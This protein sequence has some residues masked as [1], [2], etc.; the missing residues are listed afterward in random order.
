MKYGINTLIFTGTFTDEDARVFETIAQMGF[1]G[2]EIALEKKGDFDYGSVLKK[3]RNNDLECSSI[4][5]L[6]GPDRDVRGPNKEY[7]KNGIAYIKDCIDAAYELEAGLVIGPLYSSVGR[8]NMESDEAKKEQWATARESL[9]EVCE[10]AEKKGID[11]ALEPL[12]RFETDFINI[13]RDA[14]AMVDEVGSSRLGIHLDAFHMNIE[15]KNSA[16]AV[17]AA[18]KKLFH[19]HASENDRGTP[20]T[21]Q[22]RWDEIAAAFKEIDYNRY[23]VIE[24]FTPDIEIIAKAASIWRPTERDAH[25]LADK[26]LRYI[27]KL[28]G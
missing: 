1:D 7:V 15:E 2:V 26:G 8:A 3:L 13:C 12:N 10:Y 22:V 20:G 23:V 25:T 11:L 28:F 9:E 24:S 19:F 21:G 17:R 4:C 16:D 14:L 5:G 27:K 6:F 18:G